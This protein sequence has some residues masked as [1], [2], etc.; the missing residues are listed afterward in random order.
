MASVED[1]LGQPLTD[2]ELARAIKS[3]SIGV[4]REEG[5]TLYSAGLTPGRQG[6]AGI[7]YYAVPRSRNKLKFKRPLAAR[8]KIDAALLLDMPEREVARMAGY[9][10]DGWKRKGYSIPEFLS[11]VREYDPR[12][13]L[14]QF[15]TSIAAQAKRQ[16]YDAVILQREAVGR[17]GMLATEIIDLSSVKNP[18]KE[19]YI[20]PSKSAI[21]D[22]KRGLEARKKAP[23][24]KKGGLSAMQAAEEGVGSGVLR[25]RDIVAGKKVN[26]YQVK[27]FFD[28]HRQNYLNAKLKG[29]K[30]EESKA[31][32]AWLLWGGEP[33]RKQVERAVKM[34]RPKAKRSKRNPGH[35]EE[36]FLS[37]G[38]A[39]GSLIIIEHVD[40]HG[41]TFTTAVEG[42]DRA[43]ALK[44]ALES[45]P[46]GAKYT[47]QNPS[48]SKKVAERAAKKAGKK[49]RFNP[50]KGSTSA[51][52]LI[53]GCQLKW[54][55]YCERPSKKRLKAVFDHLETMK[56][57]KSAKVKSERRR[58]LRVANLEAKRLK[59]KR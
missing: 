42:V 7:Y 55:S 1:A 43:Q 59:M 40:E 4:V 10:Q 48:K 15:D 27:A 24:S 26:A 35:E 57:S 22:A 44:Y 41:R 5:H 56:A 58:C 13:I 17:H 20:K 54:E 52:E 9:V 38:N 2:A 3:G 53:Q 51:S 46:E 11:I 45:I 6:V 33:L 14:D 28:R 49:Q 31:I 8:N 50:R 39:D 16:G 12:S 47:I 36:Y 21:R 37:S 19:L 23:K 30:P 25:A 34:D 32:Q 18:R 29:L